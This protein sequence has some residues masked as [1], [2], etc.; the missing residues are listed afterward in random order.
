MLN[1]QKPVVPLVNQELAPITA[2]THKRAK[3]SLGQRD[4]WYG[5]LFISPM[6]LGYIV[7]L[8]GP[9]VV[10]FGMSFTNWSLYEGS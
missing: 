5:Y 8:F 4:K 10:A 2:K 3:S 7:F 1:R 9:I 6:V